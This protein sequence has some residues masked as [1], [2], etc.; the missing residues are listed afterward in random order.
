MSKDTLNNIFGIPERRPLAQDVVDS[1][2][3]AIWSGQLQPGMRLREEELADLLKVSRGPIREALIQ[4]E[5]EGL[6]VRQPNR[7]A[8]VARLSREDLEEVYSLRVALERLAIRLVV[9]DGEAHYLD[10][11]QAVIDKMK[12]AFDE[13]VTEQ[14]AA[15]LDVSFHEV[16]YRAA[17]HKRLYDLWSILRPQIHIF[18][19]SRNV[20]NPDFREYMVPTHQEILDT[21]RSGNEEQAVKVIEEHLHGAYERVLASYEQYMR[22]HPVE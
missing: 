2:R 10:E 20:A 18:F 22:D 15:E 16:I 17:H 1:L 5:L 14:K 11:M 9:R 7:G 3:Q 6:V 13:G 21:I 8:T 12:A 19:L 4:L